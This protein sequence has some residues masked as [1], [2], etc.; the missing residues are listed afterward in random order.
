MQFGET[1]AF[2]LLFLLPLLVG[3]F[4]W[5]KQRK[6]K[7]AAR[8]GEMALVAKLAATV[9]PVRDRV[10]SVLFLA[11]LFFFILTLA[12]PQ[13]G[14]KTEQVVRSGVDV[15]LAIDTSFSMDATDVVPSR[16]EKARHIAS[17]LMDALQG[18]R[19]GLI[20]FSGSAFVQC[21]LTLDY[22][23]AKIFLDSFSTGVVPEPG[24]NIVSALAMA[25][26]GFVAKESK[27]KVVILLTDGEQHEG[28]TMAAAEAARDAGILVHAVGVGTPGG[29]P[30]PV[31]DE[32]GEVTE[33]KRDERRPARFEPPGRGHL[34]AY[35]RD[36]RREIFSRHRPGVGGRRDCRAR[37][38][39]GEQGAEL[40]ALHSVRRKVLL[41]SGDRHCL[42]DGGDGSSQ[43]PWQEEDRRQPGLAW[44][45]K[46]TMRV[47]TFILL[48]SIPGLGGGVNQKNKEGAEL[49]QEGKL[50]EALTS[51]TQAQVESPDAPE[52]H[53]NIGNVHYRKEEMD[54]SVEEYRASLRGEEDVQQ[55]AH[56]N[57]GN[58]HYKKQDFGSAVQSYKQALKI[59]PSDI[60]ARQNLE[61]ALKQSEDGGG[62]ESGEGE[63]DEEQ[64][65]NKASDDQQREDQDKDQQQQ[66]QTDQSDPS[67]MSKEEA[68]RLLAA[69]AE[70]EKTE[71]RHQQQKKYIRVK[72]KGKDW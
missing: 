48:A 23:A 8:F 53:Y 22:G 7:A 60:E 63:D 32:R 15:F 70:M 29:D 41:A 50:D 10:K 26:R 34:G 57:V 47:L 5:A 62:G 46:W 38:G 17:A 2:Y 30:I 39:H 68:E 20:V 59:D 19:I 43:T 72:G 69:L 13:W 11:A 36:H 65:E 49:Y 56:Y 54:K 37:G 24:T 64:K 28:D 9:S 31:L 66:P 14:Q 21:P 71:Q 4:V 52:I 1:N 55:P 27:F 58:V 51:F 45:R 25:E 6:Q 33:Y 40:K 3:F 42:F 35:R 44:Q 67:S 18:N 16:I 12:R 61:L